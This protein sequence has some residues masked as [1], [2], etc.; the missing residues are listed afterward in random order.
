MD[1]SE[2]DD[3]LSLFVF[4]LSD[5]LSEVLLELGVELELVSW[6]CA[7]TPGAASARA[8]TDSAI[9]LIR[10][11]HMGVCVYAKVGD[12]ASRKQRTTP[13]EEARETDELA[14]EGPKHE[15]PGPLVR[16]PA[17]R[18]KTGVWKGYAENDEPHPQ[19]CFAFGFLNENPLCPNWPST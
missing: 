18:A 4:A 15:E 13:R 1:L 12:A 16:H 2:L 19:V 9:N 3:E 17:L 11:L 5:L 10:C 8:R 7:R 6:L 14:P